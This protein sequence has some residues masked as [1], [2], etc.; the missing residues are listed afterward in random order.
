MSAS[1][2]SRLDA[3]EREGAARAVVSL[4]LGGTC[5][6]CGLKIWIEATTREVRN[7]RAGERTI[8][9]SRGAPGAGAHVCKGL[10]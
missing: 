7:Q 8:G 10:H 9:V 5:A 3:L 2:E 1:I 6:R 4:W